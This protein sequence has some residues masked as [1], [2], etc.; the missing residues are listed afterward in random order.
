[1]ATTE[2]RL[3]AAI[4][5]YEELYARLMAVADYLADMSDD[6]PYYIAMADRWG[7]K[8]KMTVS[9]ALGC[10]PDCMGYDDDGNGRECWRRLVMASEEVW[11]EWRS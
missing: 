9:R 7:S 8:K 4:D 10:P 5:K 1:M 11:E 6:C 2:E 3:D